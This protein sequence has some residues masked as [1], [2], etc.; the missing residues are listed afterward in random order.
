MID[1]NRWNAGER[2]CFAYIVNPAE[3]DTLS[4]CESYDQTAASYIEEM[5]AEIEEMKAYRQA[6]FHRMQTLYSIPYRLKITLTREKRYRGNVHY[7]LRHWKE[8]I[9]SDIPLEET[10]CTE[11]PGTDRA[12]AIK[13]YRLALKDHPGV[14]C[15]MDIAK[16]KF[17][18]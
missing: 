14:A 5:T 10:S 3:L 2:K 9:G 15:E 8:Y 16:G 18:R 6:V 7:Y 12:Q 13:D 17:E 4:R 1:W 11:Y